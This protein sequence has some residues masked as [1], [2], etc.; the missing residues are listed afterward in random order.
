MKERSRVEQF[1]LIRRAS[2]EEG[3]SVRELAR[4]FEV[5]RRTVRQ[6]LLDAT[7]PVRKTPVRTAP[8]LGAH[9]QTVRGW[10]IEDRAAPR[11]QRHTARRVWQR[12]VDEQ[13]AVVAES[14]VRHLVA[15]LRREVGS[16]IGQVM[17]PQTHAPAE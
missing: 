10:L 3:L 12:L 13:D 4:R 14:T 16:G 8:T 1:E 17:V 2:R 15:R 5:H 9:V 6:A 7:P 11:K